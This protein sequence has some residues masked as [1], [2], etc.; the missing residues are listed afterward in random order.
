MEKSMYEDRDEIVKEIVTRL[1]EAAQVDEY[2]A[3][4][5]HRPMLIVIAD[6]IERLQLELSEVKFE[7]QK[8]WEKY[9]RRENNG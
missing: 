9:N 7:Y 1:R 2:Y 3:V 5:M 8:L 4:T 6:E